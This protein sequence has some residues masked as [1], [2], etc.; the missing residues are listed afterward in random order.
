[1]RTPL[2]LVLLATLLTLPAAPARSY[3]LQYTG[4]SATLQVKWPTTT[5]N[6]A[7]STSLNA[8]PANIEATPAEVVAAARR[9]LNTWA[10]AAG[11]QFVVTTS[12]VLALDPNDNVSL[13][14]VSP[15]NSGQFSCNPIQQG[16]AR[17]SFDSVSGNIVEGDVAINPNP[18]LR[19]STDGR[20]GTFDLESTFVHEIGHVLG[21]E[22]SG[23]AGA[24][25]QPRQ[26]T[27]GTYGLPALTTRTVSED[28]RAGLRAIYGPHS[29]AGAIS[30]VVNYASGAPAFGAHVWAE[31]VA[32]GEVVAGN[33]A[34]PSGAYRIDGL[35]AGSY[36]VMA[37][38]LNE[39]V[40]ATQIA[41]RTGAYLG[42]ASV[43]APFAAR[44]V[45]TFDVADGAV[46][47]LSFTV[48]G[49]PFL[50]PA[51]IGTGGQLSKVATPLVPGRTTSVLVG[52]DGITDGAFN[53]LA[54]PS[55]NSPHMTVSNVQS[56]GL[57]FGI[58][59]IS[60]DLTVGAAAAPGEYSVRLQNGAGEVAFVAG[61]LTIDL[62][63]GVTAGNLIDD[64]TFFVAQ[65]YRD[66]LGR[67]PD[68]GGLQFWT[69]QITSCGADTA[70]R[71]IR[72]I[73]ASAA[74]FQSI[75]FQETG[76][77]VYRAH[78]A[79]FATRE[80]L[81]FHDFQLEQQRVSRGV[82]IGVPGAEA[83][84]EANKQAYLNEFVAR[85]DFLARYPAALSPEQFVDALNQ[86]AGG[87]LSAEERNAL[88]FDLTN[89]ARTRAQVLRAVAEDADLRAAE[90]RRAF[91]L[92]E[93]FGYLRRNPADPPESNLNFDGYNF[94]LGKLNQFNGNF[95]SAE[96]VKAFIT[97]GEY[98]QRFG[99]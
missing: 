4:P 28:D 62:P 12:D 42:L 37:E 47:P 68:A 9:A 49:S 21:L 61:G 56:Q 53:I 50:N 65:H 6:I 5:I 89:G 95:V 63:S 33:I 52:G 91:V 57:G 92:T 39:P 83:L 69:N 19:F 97:S 71:E 90:F 22:H 20:A 99:L 13:I 93:Y 2:T 38:H 77:L 67:E 32:T 8:P 43:T 73:N 98:R 35:P 16:R 64:T 48:S 10:E 72:R 55:V 25:M 23:V 59:V 3:T 80:R 45:G 82:V 74:F 27:N 34:L 81:R 85:P 14:T 7:L 26:G 24:S 41:S 60:F 76:F 75:E 96:M 15:A 30:G 86:N 58:P 44:E 79:A 17:T 54:T 46:T 66:F 40:D 11:V 18:C 1:M 29:G 84:L 51:W 88:A 78:T 36:R 87:A 70:C 31:S 94:W